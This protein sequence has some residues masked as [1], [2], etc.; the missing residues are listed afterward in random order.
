NKNIIKNLGLPCFVIKRSPI[1]WSGPGHRIVYKK[2][3]FN[4]VLNLFLI[5]SHIRFLLKIIMVTK[6]SRM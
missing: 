6:T 3:N 1:W 4:F 2:G 5:K